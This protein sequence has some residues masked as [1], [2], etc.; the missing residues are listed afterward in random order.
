MVLYFKFQLSDLFFLCFL[1]DEEIL[2]ETKDQTVFMFLF[3]NQR[4]EV[5]CDI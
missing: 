3:M 1:N 5:E 4:F 2:H